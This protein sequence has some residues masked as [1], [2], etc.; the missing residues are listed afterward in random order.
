M[1]YRFIDEHQEEFG[2]RWLP[3]H[4]GICVNAYYNYLKQAKAEYTKQKEQ[5]CNEIKAIYHELNGVVGHRGVKS[6]S[7]KKRN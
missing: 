2:L 7:C 1:A 6:I 4:M 3:A 5:V